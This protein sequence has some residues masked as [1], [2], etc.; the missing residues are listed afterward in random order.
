VPSRRARVKTRSSSGSRIEPGDQRGELFLT[1]GLS[2]IGSK[3]NFSRPPW[4]YLS[5]LFARNRQNGKSAMPVYSL[6]ERN[7]I[8]FGTLAQVYQERR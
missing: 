6:M 8:D 3:N 1:S 2:P 4:V 7:T 5:D